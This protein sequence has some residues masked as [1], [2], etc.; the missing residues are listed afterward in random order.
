MVQKQNVI[1]GTQALTMMMSRREATRYVVY[2]SS[3]TGLDN[4]TRVLVEATS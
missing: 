4:L 1:W 3:K 2:M